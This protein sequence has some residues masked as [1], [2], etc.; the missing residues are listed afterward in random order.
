MSA[1]LMDILQTCHSDSWGWAL[2][3]GVDIDLNE[4]IFLNF[5]VKYID[6]DTTATLVTG[7]AGTQSVDIDLDPLVFG[8]G[9]GFRL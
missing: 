8:I 4:N 1:P 6:I 7:G 3:A 2:Q 9:I 5:D